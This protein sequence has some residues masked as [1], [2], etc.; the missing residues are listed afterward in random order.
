MITEH[1]WEQP[2]NDIEEHQG[3]KLA[4]REDVIAN[5]DLGVGIRLH[6][7]IHTTVAPADEE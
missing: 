4:P 1:A 5:G 7:R 2:P 3:G 6:P